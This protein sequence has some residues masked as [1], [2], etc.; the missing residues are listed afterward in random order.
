[1]TEDIGGFE[2]E[3]G[4]LTAAQLEALWV[5]AGVVDATADTVG[6]TLL[7]TKVDPWDARESLPRLL[8]E[9]ADFELVEAIAE[10]GTAVVHRAMQRS[11]G[12]D[13]AVKIL[14]GDRR[15][16]RMRAQLLREARIAG[17]LEH[18]N[19][20]PVHAV[21]TDADGEP[22]LV[23]KRVEGI[24][25]RAYMAAPD[26]RV[27]GDSPLEQQLEV[28]QLVARAVH[29][30]HLRGVL[31]RDIK[32][33][34][35]MLG[36]FGEVYLLDWG[37]AV[38]M[39]GG[40]AAPQGVAGTPGYMAPEMA[41]SEAVTAR[42][43]VYLLG[44]VLHEVLTGGPPHQGRS[45][46]SAMMAA[47]RADGPDYG[48][49]VPAELAAVAYRAMARAPEDRYP[50]AEAFRRAV[51]DYARH[52]ESY[53]VAHEA[54]RRLEAMAE[55]SSLAECHR[56]FGAARFGFEQ[57]LRIWPEN[58]RARTG[59]WRTLS[60]MALTEAREG[61]VEAAE[62]LLA[63]VPRPDASVVEAVEL[64]RRRSSE[65]DRELAS[66]R[67]MERDLDTDVGASARFRVTLGLGFV[68]GLAALGFGWVVRRTL[69]GGPQPE[70]YVPHALGLC[71]V[72]AVALLLQHRSLFQNRVNR[73]ISLLGMLAFASGLYFR[74][75]LTLLELPFERYLPLEWA[76][77]AA[78]LACMGLFDRRRLAWSGAPLAVGALAMALW[79]TWIYELAGASVFV[80]LGTLAVL[81]RPVQ[82][83]AD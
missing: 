48:D 38:R 46:Y 4:S 9:G 61:R 80:A 5:E 39:N 7:P 12:R 8:G 40:T 69:P 71:V 30:A 59:L 10:G 1:M 68:L 34:N 3:R 50:S 49:G 66:L 52:R 23:M 27:P 24:S 22:A 25:W 77:Y 72:G 36:R 15:S 60:E 2:S 41:A 70:H 45:L 58:G 79:P 29:F 26:G 13:V 35:V 76:M 18:P 6:L 83:P 55:A 20:I 33:D 65:A 54:D 81:W 17:E 28:L 32:P 74:V 19:V 37:I 56:H 63:Q 11:V 44:A 43:D 82:Q 75:L 78:L 16:D 73:R 42:T 57:A 21:G 64:A 47:Y 67:A 53:V 31:H 62:A 14:R 51:R